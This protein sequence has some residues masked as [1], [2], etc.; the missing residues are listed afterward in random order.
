MTLPIN[1]DSKCFQ[2]AWHRL[3]TYES[4]ITLE[5][6]YNPICQKEELTMMNQSQARSIR[7][8]LL[9]VSRNI[10][11][12]KDFLARSGFQG[13]RYLEIMVY[14]MP[15]SNFFLLLPSLPGY[16]SSF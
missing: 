15:V 12:Y 16:S 5:C 9:T 8:L 3:T 10:P 6:G 2:K 14:S 7:I 1:P 4:V 11:N 13:C